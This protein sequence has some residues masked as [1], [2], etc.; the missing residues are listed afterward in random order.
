MKDIKEKKKF[1]PKY[2][3]GTVNGMK[4][5]SKHDDYDDDE[6]QFN[7]KKGISNKTLIKIALLCIVAIILFSVFF[8]IIKNSIDFNGVYYETPSEDEVIEVVVDPESEEQ[9]QVNL[10]LKGELVIEIEKGV[11][12]EDPGYEAISSIDGDISDYVKVTG[13]VDTSKVGTYELV[14]E[15]EY[16]VIAPKLTRLV[17]VVGKEEEKEPEKTP[18]GGNK[19]PKPSSKPAV[20]PQKPSTIT[21]SLIGQ[22]TVYLITGSSYSDAGASA[23]DNLGNNVSNQITKSG[24]V[25]TNVAGTYKITYS[26]NNYNG[27]VLTVVRNVVV[28]SMKIKL[29]SSIV[30]SKAIINVSITSVDNFSHIKLPDG[31]TTKEQQ[32]SYS[33]TKNGTYSFIVYNNNGN[34]KTF[35]ITV[36]NIQPASRPDPSCSL[37]ANAQG[38]IVINV[39]VKYNPAVQY[40]SAVLYYVYNGSKFTDSFTTQIKKTSCVG[41]LRGVVA[42]YD[43]GESRTVTCNCP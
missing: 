19:T 7:E 43:D 39:G 37:S 18:G 40:N 42:V 28:Q 24:S 31:T 15:L 25:N 29:S 36:N 41:S 33:V 20:T 9:E 3:E 16:K 35:T 22:D 8:V 27:Q 11:E 6:L 26:I 13:E 30:G 34:S 12:W 14:Y 1:E 5:E 4:F 10:K 2:K 23:V 38:K 21:L 32:L 17:K